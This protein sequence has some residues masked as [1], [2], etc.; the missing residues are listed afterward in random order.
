MYC[1]HC[2]SLNDD[3]SR[4]CKA[5][6]QVLAER[7][8]SSEG[9]A[10]PSSMVSPSAPAA[11]VLR[12]SL[13]HGDHKFILSEVDF[14]DESGSVAYTA[15]RE[16]TL[17]ENYT[18]SH[19]ET[20][21]LYMRRKTH[22]NGYSFELQDGSGGAAGEVRCH[23]TNRKGQPP[24]YSYT[25]LQG[26]PRAAIVWERGTLNFAICDPASAQVFALA[27]A[28]LPG[29]AK[30]DLKALIHGQ[31]RI[32]IAEGTPLPLP[33]VLAFCVTV[34]DMPPI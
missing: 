4:F 22:L 24:E 28:V 11:Q 12:F 30:G 16:S 27:S 1:I 32:S 10:T 8:A 15:S 6:G 19:G 18:I 21:L 31:H 2:G 14:Q 29:G 3:Q 17:H 26:N 33:V 23:F 20:R 9:A 5:C 7:D 25:D 34:A 13:T